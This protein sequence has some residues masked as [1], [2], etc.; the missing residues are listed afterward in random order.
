VIPAGMRYRN[1]QDNISVVSDKN[2]SISIT[3]PQAGLYWMSVSY[4]DDKAQ[5]P[6][7]KRSGSYVATF[8]VL[9]E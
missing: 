1:Q 2:G 6:A 5:K 8:E 3:W 7:K 9:P 4:E